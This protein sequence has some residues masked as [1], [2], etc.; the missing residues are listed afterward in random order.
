MYINSNQIILFYESN[1]S[2]YFYFPV[3]NH[4]LPKKNS[5]DDHMSFEIST[6]GESILKSEINNRTL[7]KK[8]FNPRTQTSNSLQK[9]TS[10]FLLIRK[11]VFYL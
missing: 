11:N 4:I 1:I 2:F 5:F 10:K 9:S 7:Q 6:K 3:S 8:T